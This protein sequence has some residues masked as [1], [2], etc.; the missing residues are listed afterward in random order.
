MAY[1]FLNSVTTFREKS[2]SYFRDLSIGSR[3]YW[4]LLYRRGISGTYKCR[5]TPF[6]MS[7][8]VLYPAFLQNCISFQIIVE[9][10]SILISTSLPIRWRFHDS[11]SSPALDG[12]SG[13][14]QPSVITDHTATN[15]MEHLSFC[16]GVGLPVGK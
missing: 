8:I 5:H 4:L 15:N 7:H 2:P 16:T 12:H 10:S 11:S 3:C 14:L 1:F 9:S 6:F 13:W